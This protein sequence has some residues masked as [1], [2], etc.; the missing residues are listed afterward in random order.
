MLPRA[1]IEFLGEVYGWTEFVDRFTH[2]RTD[3]PTADNGA[4]IRL[5][6]S[7]GRSAHAVIERAAEAAVRHRHYRDPRQPELCG[8]R[9]QMAETGEQSR[10]GL[11]QI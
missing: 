1:R 9:I 10:G 4:A 11:G 8:L 6:A 2:L 5:R 7:F 3:N